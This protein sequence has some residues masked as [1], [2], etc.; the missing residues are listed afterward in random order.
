MDIFFA[1]VNYFLLEPLLG[2]GFG[3]RVGFAI[4]L[5]GVRL[6]CPLLGLP[7]DL[8]AGFWVLGFLAIG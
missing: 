3:G 6:N 1:I 2:N 8:G 4:V 5:V 7:A